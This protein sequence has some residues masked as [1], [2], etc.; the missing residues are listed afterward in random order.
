MDISK[1]DGTKPVKTINFPSFENGQNFLPDAVSDDNI[2]YIFKRFN[3]HFVKPVNEDDCK[4]YH[5]LIE[6]Q[7]NPSRFFIPYDPKFFDVLYKNLIKSAGYTEEKLKNMKFPG[8]PDKI[9]KQ[10]TVDAKCRIGNGC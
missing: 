8:W 3:E 9:P 5:K 10:E 2:L 1:F 7:E 6:N 4:R